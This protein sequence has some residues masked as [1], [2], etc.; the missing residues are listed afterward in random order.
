MHIMP[1]GS[2]P[3]G[4]QEK[5]HGAAVQRVLLLRACRFPRE[6]SRALCIAGSFA[7]GQWVGRVE[8]FRAA[9]GGVLPRQNMALGSGRGPVGTHSWAFAE[10]RRA[11]GISGG[12]WGAKERLE[13]PMMGRCKSRVDLGGGAWGNP[14]VA[15]GSLGAGYPQGY[16]A[17]YTT[18]HATI[19]QQSIQQSIQ[20]YIQQSIFLK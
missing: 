18:I 1:S 16:T 11:W 15:Q 4:S 10:P 19:R 7:W 12:A 5:P 9:W 6:T 14:W 3:M 13:G 20:Q 8:R 17:T 2:G